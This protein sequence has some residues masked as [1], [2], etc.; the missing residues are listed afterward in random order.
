V[1][2]G[3]NPWRVALSLA[4]RELRGGLKGFRVFLASVQSNLAW[5]F[6]TTRL[7]T[8]ILNAVTKKDYGPF[9]EE[10]YW[11]LGLPPAK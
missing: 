7:V 1:S 2:D 10:Y 6:G 9:M 11:G 8:R 5:K 4:R 3:A